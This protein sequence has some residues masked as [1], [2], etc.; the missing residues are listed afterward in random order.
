[1]TLP[2]EYSMTPLSGEA[3]KRNLRRIHV[4]VTIYAQIKMFN[5][6]QSAKDRKSTSSKNEWINSLNIFSLDA[7]QQKKREMQETCN[8]HFVSRN[9]SDFGLETSEAESFYLNVIVL[10]DLFFS[11]H[12]QNSI[13]LRYQIKT[14]LLLLFPCSSTCLHENKFTA[15][16]ALRGNERLIAHRSRFVFPFSV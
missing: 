11:F 7:K 13:Y 16:L 5:S 1:M 3:I 8:Q 14:I 6:L 4:Q 15:F 10:W 9:S 12:P 2:H